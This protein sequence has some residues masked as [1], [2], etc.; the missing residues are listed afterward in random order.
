[1]NISH[2]GHIDDD[3][4]NLLPLYN[5]GTIENTTFFLHYKLPMQMRRYVHTLRLCD[6]IL[7]EVQC[8]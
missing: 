1:M 4:G 8:A 2:G 3:F 6:C 7:L 5:R